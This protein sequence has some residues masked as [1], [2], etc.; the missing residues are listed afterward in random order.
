MTIFVTD[1]SYFPE[2]VALRGEVFSQ[3]YPAD[4]ICE[5]QALAYPEL[6]FEIEAIAL[7]DGNTIDI[8]HS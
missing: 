2:V 8:A 3:P 6:M 1:M 4:T 5:V 7:V